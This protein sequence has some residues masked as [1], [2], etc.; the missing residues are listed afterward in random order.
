MLG[1]LFAGA[2]RT[3]CRECRHVFPMNR[4]AKAVG[5]RLIPCCPRC[6]TLVDLRALPQGESDSR[7][8]ALQHWPLA[9]VVAAGVAFAV[10]LFA[11]ALAS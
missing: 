3:Q 4:W 1:E 2:P 8:P 10:L 7:R 11:A 5:D 9:T 6:Y